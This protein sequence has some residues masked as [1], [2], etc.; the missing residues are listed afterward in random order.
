MHNIP[1]MLQTSLSCTEAENLPQ[2]QLARRGTSCSALVRANALLVGYGLI[3]K[4]LATWNVFP[5][6][7]NGER[8]ASSAEVARLPLAVCN[9]PKHVQFASA[10]DSMLSV[11]RGFALQH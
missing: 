10:A 6:W 5:Q 3:D 1:D 2:P 7:N 11:P 9:N 4:A 8:A